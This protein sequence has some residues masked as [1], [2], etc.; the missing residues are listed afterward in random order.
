MGDDIITL[1]TRFWAKV[2]R[3]DLFDCWLW[4]AT[5]IQ[6]G[7]GHFYIAGRLD[8]AHR[9]AYELTI[10]PIPAGLCV[11][12]HCDNPP[13]VN[14]AHLWLGTKADNMADC[15]AK[16]RRPDVRGENNSRAKLT[17]E[18]VREIRQDD[19]V[20]WIIAAKYGV[21]F[22]TINHIRSRRTWAHI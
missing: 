9:V 8:L 10:G 14:P 13:C 3:T 12:H 19:R 22:N 15:R 7:Y 16:G 11:L 6:Q 2:D 21:S 18:N 5:R 20:G 17:E 1:K 4:T